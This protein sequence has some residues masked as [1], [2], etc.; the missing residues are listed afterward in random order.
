METAR[1]VIGLLLVMPADTAA[2]S[3]G[4]TPRTAWGHPDLQGVWDFRTIT[5]M[6]RPAA[7][8][9]RE[10]LT[11]EEAAAYEAEVNR[12]Q[13]RDL[14]DPAKGGASYPPESE[15]GVVPYNEFWYDRGS[16]LVAG[17]RTSLVVDP[18]DG[19]IPPLTAAARRRQAAGAQARTGVGRHEPTPGGWVEDIGPGHLAVR[20]LAGLNSGPPM[21]PGGNTRTFRCSRPRITSCCSTR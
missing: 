9:G 15:G 7:L 1:I 5:P 2:Q 20:C 21:D 8:A 18:P 3:N 12:R 19:R 10:V 6:E 11:E 16:A 14:I 4:D 13:N 17:R